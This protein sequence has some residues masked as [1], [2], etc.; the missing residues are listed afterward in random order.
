M[1]ITSGRE[2]STTFETANN[3][4]L[5]NN[6]LQ[7]LSHFLLVLTLFSTVLKI[8]MVTFNRVHTAGTGGAVG[9]GKDR[10]RW[11][12]GFL[13]FPLLFVRWLIHPHQFW[14]REYRHWKEAAVGGGGFDEAV[15]H[16]RYHHVHEEYDGG[17][18]P[19]APE[20]LS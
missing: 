17:F 4:N 14:I 7:D 6:I 20:S 13:F 18:M 19:H 9:G 10:G 16:V 11:V 2:S 1:T 15:E 8:A 5:P 12:P 3:N